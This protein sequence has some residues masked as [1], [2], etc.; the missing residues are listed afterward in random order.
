M[1]LSLC[2]FC[3][4][5]CM[6]L[7]LLLLLFCCMLL[8]LISTVTGLY[9][10]LKEAL[11]ISFP[12]RLL[13]CRPWIL[14]RSLCCLFSWV[15]L[16]FL[17]FQLFFMRFFKCGSSYS[18]SCHFCSCCSTSDFFFF[19]CSAQ[20]AFETI[21]TDSGFQYRSFFRPFCECFLLS[22]RAYMMLFRKRVHQ[23]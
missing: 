22:A 20:C 10:V 15:L 2:C 23:H 16:L 18:Y 13:I 19:S 12:H 9:N 6:L 3:C 21:F 14:S 11:I 17:S 1:L 4:C 8:L 5:C 7:L